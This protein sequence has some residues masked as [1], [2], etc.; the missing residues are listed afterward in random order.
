ML[1]SV[2]LECTQPLDQTGLLHYFGSESQNLGLNIN[3]EDVFVVPR[4]EKFLIGPSGARRAGYLI[5]FSR[6]IG[7][8]RT[9]TRI[10]IIYVVNLYWGRSLQHQNAL[11]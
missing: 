6:I 11:A 2:G 7:I 10:S 1:D 9:D 3:L 8:A 4:T 5:I